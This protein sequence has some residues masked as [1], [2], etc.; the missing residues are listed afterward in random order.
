MN[1]EFA[2]AFTMFYAHA[3]TH[4]LERVEVV[5]LR[6]RN[7]GLLKKGTYEIGD[8]IWIVLSWSHCITLRPQADNT[9]WYSSVAFVPHWETFEN[10]KGFAEISQAGDQIEGWVVGDIELA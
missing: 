8:D 6:S 3:H 9:Y 5:E 10:S 4:T 7:L 1:I 2:A